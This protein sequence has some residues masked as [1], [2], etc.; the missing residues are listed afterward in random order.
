[1]IKLNKQREAFSMIVAIALIIIMATLTV[2]ITNVSG[3]LGKETTAIFQK[4]QAKLLAKSYTEYAIMA[5]SANDRVNND[6]IDTINGT[7]GTPATGFGYTVETVISYIG[8]GDVGTCTKILSQTVQH[9]ASQLSIVVDVYVKYKEILHK[10]HANSPWYTY[11]K[12]S[13]QKI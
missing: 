3:K 5:V 4:E 8:N 6:C 11:H 13:L 1:M 7:I 10:D 2:L 9:E 12:R